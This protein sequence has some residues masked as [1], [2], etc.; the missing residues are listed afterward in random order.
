MPGV[1]LKDSVMPSSGQKAPLQSSSNSLEVSRPAVRTMSLEDYWVLEGMEYR[2]DGGY[3]FP[4]PTPAWLGFFALGIK[5][6][7]AFFVILQTSIS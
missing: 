2:H 6:E 3:V 7:E 4:S 1:L 5:T